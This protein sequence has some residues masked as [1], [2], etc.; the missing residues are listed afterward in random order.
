MLGGNPEKLEWL[1]SSRVGVLKASKQA[2]LEILKMN[3]QYPEPKHKMKT[4]HLKQCIEIHELIEYRS[5]YL[6]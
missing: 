4:K 5:F 6:R 2:N 1:N 3:R